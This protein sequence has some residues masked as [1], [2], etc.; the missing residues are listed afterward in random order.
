M[1][2]S[3]EPAA[4]TGS[5][6]ARATTA[7]AKR[8]TAEDLHGE[9]VKAQQ[10]QRAADHGRQA[11]G[12]GEVGGVLFGTGAGHVAAGPDEIGDERPF[13]VVAQIEMAR[14]IPVVGLI[15]REVERAIMGE[16]GDVQAGR[17][18]D[19][20]RR[21]QATRPNRQSGQGAALRTYGDLRASNGTPGSWGDGL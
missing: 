18:Q 13:A 2:I 4:M 20:H 15:G 10:Q 12:E 19:Q 14:P 16:I 5:V 1:V 9:N 6:N 3:V 21:Q 8:L 17:A 7:K 11:H